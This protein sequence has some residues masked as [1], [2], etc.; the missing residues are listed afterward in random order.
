VNFYLPRKESEFVKSQPRDFLVNLV[1][2][3][4]EPEDVRSVPQRPQGRDVRPPGL[5][6]YG[7]S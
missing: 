4:M 2:A 1:R 3:A 7:K 6:R 5:P